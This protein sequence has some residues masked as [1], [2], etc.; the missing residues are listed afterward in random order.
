MSFRGA[1]H[2]SRLHQPRTRAMASAELA[3][4]HVVTG[5]RITAPT[6]AI[7]WRACPYPLA[8]RWTGRCCTGCSASVGSLRW[9]C[10]VSVEQGNEG[11]V[12]F[13]AAP[14]SLPSIPSRC[15]SPSRKPIS[16]ASAQGW[17]RNPVKLSVSLDPEK[18][19]NYVKC[20]EIPGFPGLTLN[21]SDA[22]SGEGWRKRWDSN[23]RTARTV[24]GFQDQCLKPLG[25]S[26]CITAANQ[27]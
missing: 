19:W 16:N 21:V 20:A 18:C 4:F 27:S 8:L 22:F 24:A 25:H 12:S 14:L 26:S 23:P 9:W 15:F 2:S 13:L 17:L 7:R 6:H 10:F 11:L 5:G 1:L 3:V